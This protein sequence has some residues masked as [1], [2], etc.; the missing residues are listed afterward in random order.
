L[1]LKFCPTCGKELEENAKFCNSCG[2]DL[3][4]PVKISN[5]APVQ[6]EHSAKTKAGVKQPSGGVVYADLL[7]RLGAIIIDVLIIGSIGSF[8]TLFSF[9]FSLLN[10]WGT[11]QSSWWQTTL[12][13]YLIGFIYFWALES[14]NRGQ[15]LGK[16]ALKLRT[17]DSATLQV[18]DPGKNAINNLAKASPL[19]ILDLIIGILSNSGD[20]TKR[21]RILQNLSETVVVSEKYAK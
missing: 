1:S 13:D 4:S 3:S 8:I 10:L 12:I 16:M 17:V 7:P 6:S 21:L 2:A 11:F 18:A 5:T 20:H 9:G 15:T 19:L 14:F